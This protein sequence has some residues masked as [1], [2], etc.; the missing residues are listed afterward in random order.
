MHG[1]VRCPRMGT[2]V[3][4]IG[5]ERTRPHNVGCYWWEVAPTSTARPRQRGGTWYGMYVPCKARDRDGPSR[6]SAKPKRTTDGL[7]L[8]SGG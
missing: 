8:L 1:H 4:G 3:M 2:A 7:M 6:M 5:V